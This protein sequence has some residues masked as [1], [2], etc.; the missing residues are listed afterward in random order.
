MARLPN[1]PKI[2]KEI[3]EGR[4]AQAKR[5]EQFV[6]HSGKGSVHN[7]INSLGQNSYYDMYR[8]MVTG[9][10]NFSPDFLKDL[11]KYDPKLNMEWLLTGEGYMMV[12]DQTS[13]IT[14][15]DIAPPKQIAADATSGNYG[16]EYS[17]P[18]NSM[19]PNI[20]KGDIL[21]YSTLNA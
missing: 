15:K 10:R 16:N 4:K 12:S 5:L 6:A 21:T 17:M 13:A 20:I 9:N 7:M 18:D 14:Q 1:N 11:T 3:I 19:A 2:R 8:K